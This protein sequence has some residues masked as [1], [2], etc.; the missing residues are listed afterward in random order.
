MYFV[1]LLMLRRPPSATR[2]DTLFPDTTLF[3]S[4]ILDGLD[5]NSY[6]FVLHCD[7]FCSFPLAEILA[8]HKTHQKECTILGKI[9]SF[10][11]SFQYIGRAHVLTPV[12]HAHLVCRPLP[13]NNKLNLLLSST[14]Y[15]SNTIT[16]IHVQ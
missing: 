13:V 16:P 4:E 12:T 2:T 6:I 10:F 11:F 7:V 5:D 14:L 3:R 1:V 8:F 15:N 9:V